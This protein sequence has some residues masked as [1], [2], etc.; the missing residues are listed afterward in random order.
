MALVLIP[1]FDAVYEN[2][3]AALCNKALWR[4]GAETI[5]DTVEDTKQSRVCKSVY[6]QTRDELLRTYPFNF[7][8]KTS[9]IPQDTAF[10]L[11]M[12]QYSYAFKAENHLAFTGTSAVGNA[13]ITGVGV[14]IIDYASLVGRGVYGAGIPVNARIVAVNATTHTITLD[15]P[16]TSIGSAFT[17][18][19]PVLK[20]LT[21]AANPETL[22]EVVQGGA[23]KRILCNM[24][25][26][27]INTENCLE[28]KYIEQ[29]LDPTKFDSMFADALV[30]RLASKLA[31]TLANSAGLY[32]ALQQEFAAVM[33]M[34]QDATA[35]EKQIDSAD[36]W[37]TDRQNVNP[38][39]QARQ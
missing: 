27:V 35:Q 4:I 39:T 10:V 24:S 32:Q 26:Q 23:D 37:W 20:I 19:L 11:P 17:V 34:A 7:A 28:L 1:A 13:T 6:A 29:V 22:F 31:V 8:T 30:L 12:N 9:Y 2:L 18:F 36:P 3:E 15:R 38:T 14:S 16:A 25:S 33:R 5:K 21:V